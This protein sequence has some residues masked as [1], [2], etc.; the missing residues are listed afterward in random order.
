M[1][2][3]PQDSRTNLGR[4]AAIFAGGTLASRILGLVRDMVIGAYIQGASRDAFLFAF[5]FP[6][7]LR[8]MLGEGATN[9]AFVP[10]FTSTRETQSPEEY[11]RLIGAAMTAMLLLFGGLT[12]LAWFAIPYLPAVLDAMQPLTGHTAKSGEQLRSTVSLVQWTFPYLFFIGMAVFAMAPLFVAGRYGTPAWSPLLLNLSL[13]ATCLLLRSHFSDPAWALVTGVWLGGAAQLL[14]MWAA[15][16][17]HVG[18]ILPNFSLGHPGVR[19]VFLLLAPVAAGQAAGEV[20]KMVDSLFAISLEEGTVS[21]LFYANR[22]VQLPLSVFGVAMA[23]AILPGLARAGTHGNL[24]EIRGT[25]T[26]GLRQTFFLIAPATAGLMVLGGPIISLLF[27]RGEFDPYTAERAATALFYYALGLLAFSWVKICVQGF[28]AVQDT[29]TPVLVASGSM[30]LNILLNCVLV[31][32]LGYRGLALSTAIAFT[33]NFLLLYMLLTARFGPIWERGAG[34]AMLRILIATLAM[35]IAA[36]G[37]NTRAELLLGT[38][39]LG[40]RFLAVAIPMAAAVPL[41]FALCHAFRL[42]ELRLLTS[43]F[44]RRSA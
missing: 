14:V 6:N 26:H 12:L 38:D 13:I 22:L 43:I 31:G 19:R 23:A 11:R 41:Y 44:S 42:E 20:N 16:Y 34:S 32:P 37:L 29:K 15:L 7:M 24:D 1:S 9:A 28:Y 25:L 10:V 18:V 30:L 5:K 35:A 27:Q 17:R 21:A 36:Y 40:P 3:A 8:D 33:V 2:P 39:G 4:F